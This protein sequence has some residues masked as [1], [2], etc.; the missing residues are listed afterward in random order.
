VRVRPY[1]PRSWFCSID[2][3]LREEFMFY[4][5]AV[6]DSLTNEFAVWLIGVDHGHFEGL[7]R[8]TDQK[9]VLHGCGVGRSIFVL[10]RGTKRGRSRCWQFL[11][12]D[13]IL[14]VALL[15]S[16]HFET[17]GVGG[18]YKKRPRGVLLWHFCL[19]VCLF[20]VLHF[21]C[22]VLRVVVWCGVVWCVCVCVVCVWGGVCCV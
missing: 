13:F 15:I 6:I 11:H 22:C 21:L 20:F 4:Q 14:V 5:W 18:I 12:H 1:K 19:F 10:G 2:K 9:I 3:T 7:R 8:Q 16:F 17:F